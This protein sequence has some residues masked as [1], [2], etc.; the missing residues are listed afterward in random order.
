MD[1]FLDG[2]VM[3]S[4]RLDDFSQGTINE[5]K[6]AAAKKPKKKGSNPFSDCGNS[7]IDEVD[8]NIDLSG[9]DSELE[10]LLKSDEDDDEIILDG[11]PESV[12]K[13]IS[14]SDILNK[15]SPVSV[16]SGGF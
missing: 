11:K 5:F 2:D 4:G 9:N 13:S 1:A 6:S 16:G 7:E 10:A 3:M 12:K 15:L 8:M 14:K